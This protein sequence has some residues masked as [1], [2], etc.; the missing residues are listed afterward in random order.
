MILLNGYY[1]LPLSFL[2]LG[3]INLKNTGERKMRVPLTVEEVHTIIKNVTNINVDQY[4]LIEKIL[5]QVTPNS[6]PQD[7]INQERIRALVLGGQEHKIVGVTFEGRQDVLKTIQEGDILELQPEPDNQYDP[8]AV[9]VKMLDGTQAGYIPKN[10]AAMI[11]DIADQMAAR[12]TC[13]LGGDNNMAFG[14]RV[15]F[16]RK[17]TPDVIDLI[18]VG[19]AIS[20]FSEEA[21]TEAGQNLIKVLCAA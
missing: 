1:F 3:K 6:V 11:H 4:L 13:V 20:L 5:E 14:L 10:F 9:A 18:K 16:I 7:E 21:I 19:D 15:K 17:E 2:L 12:V 8:N